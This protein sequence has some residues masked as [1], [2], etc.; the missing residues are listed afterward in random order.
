MNNA[1]GTLTP[2]RGD[3]IDAVAHI[4]RQAAALVARVN[5]GVDQTTPRFEAKRA[6]VASELARR[7][8]ARLDG[9]GETA[10]AVKIARAWEMSV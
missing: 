4:W 7:L 3:A 2:E 9:L 5:P 6:E 1:I 8:L 10:L